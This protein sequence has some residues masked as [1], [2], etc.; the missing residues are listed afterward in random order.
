VARTRRDRHRGEVGETGASRRPLGFDTGR[1]SRGEFVINAD[2][3]RRN[4][5]LFESLLNATTGAITLAPTINVKVEGGSLEPQADRELGAQITTQ[6]EASMRRVVI[7]ELREQ[8]RP[9]GI[10]RA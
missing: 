8:M 3:T 5:S 1:L 6:V 2:A 4:R 9:G 10:L 7:N